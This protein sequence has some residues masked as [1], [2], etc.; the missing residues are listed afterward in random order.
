[1]YRDEP[2]VAKD[3]RTETY[4]ALKLEI[5]NWRWAGVPFYLRTG[6]RMAGRR[7]EIAVHFKP[8][9]F[10]LF[11]EA[12]GADLAPNVMRLRID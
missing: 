8:P 7:T 4:V 9:P 6:K 3:S 11:R 12:G 2:D 5:E 1:A 10:T